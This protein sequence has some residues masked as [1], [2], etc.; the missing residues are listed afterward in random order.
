M[1]VSRR[2]F[3]NRGAATAAILVLPTRSSAVPIA[4]PASAAPGQSADVEAGLKSGRFVWRNADMVAQVA[5]DPA[6]GIYIAPQSDSSGR[7]G[8]WERTFSGGIR[9]EWFGAMGDGVANDTAAFAA[10]SAVVNLR[11][12]GEVD[13][14]PTTY[15]VGAQTP[16]LGQGRV[17]GF[18]PAP[19]LDFDKCTTP[20]VIRGNGAKLKCADGLRYGTFD[21][22]SGAP[23]R[24]ALPYY[25]TGQRSTPY[26]AMI[27]VRDCTGS[28]EIRDVE[29][30][31]NSPRLRIGGPWGDVGYQIG[32]S[33]V[34]LYDNV[35]VERVISVYAH[36]HP[37][38][39][40][41]LD[42]ADVDRVG[43]SLFENV[44]CEDNG[45]QGCSI[46]GGRGYDFVRCNFARTGKAGIF[47]PPA[48][49]CDV[50]A[51]GGKKVRS[52]S[53]RDCEFSDN[54]GV[55]LLLESG[56][57][58]DAVFQTCRFI[59]TTSWAAWPR[60]PG[61]QFRDCLFVGPIVNCWGDQERP[62]DATQFV[63]CRFR[64]DPA[65][66]PAGKV[67]IGSN[68]DGPIADLPNNP[69]VHFTA[70]DFRLT[71]AHVLPWTTRAVI[72]SDCSMSQKAT[73]ISYPRG[74]FVGTNIVSGT[75]DLNGAKVLGRLTVNGVVQRRQ[76]A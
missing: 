53:F 62:Q 5:A 25:E 11:G 12:G 35:G 1:R 46:V 31:G 67:F 58:R 70:C 59:G 23:T 3:I 48:A 6:Q 29:L 38:D 19:I 28:I 36:H 34:A 17:F 20:L 65:L 21:P 42:G 9:P 71:H 55:G 52:L 13:L 41:M 49:G 16:T 24:N 2:A 22:R 39:G 51:E 76:S 64:D 73:K 40:I 47:S 45:R 15:I 54:A 60:K 32:A 75:V 27:Q 61:L 43:R 56:D 74:T 57:G 14:R 68:T 26:W 7:S 72:F 50:E 37:L 63:S 66:S 30:D 33:G 10:L 4:L 18:V 8:A 44:R 69:N